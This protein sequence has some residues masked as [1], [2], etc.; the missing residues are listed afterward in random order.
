MTKLVAEPAPAVL[1]E[2]VARVV[3]VDGN[4]VW[5]EPEQTTACGNCSASGGC[6]S[7]GLGTVLGRLARRRFALETTARLQLGERVVV[8]VR[9]DALLKAALTAYAVPLLCLILAGGL[10]QWWSGRDGVTLLA[11]LA[12]LAAGL[13]L[14]RRI[15]DYLASRG[16]LAPRLL[17]RMTGEPV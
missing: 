1:V 4:R 8:G 12:G 5:L 15:A 13:L 10:A 6:G 16:V 17:R 2:G 9:Q 14:V 7:K 3:Q 11:M